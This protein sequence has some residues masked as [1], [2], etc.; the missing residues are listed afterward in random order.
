MHY[1]KCNTKGCSGENVNVETTVKSSNDGAS[2]VFKY[3]LQEYSLN[4]K[5]KLIFTKLLA[6]LFK[7]L[8]K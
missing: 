6:S 2:D 1:Y 5:W 4:P 3:L 7:D 8:N